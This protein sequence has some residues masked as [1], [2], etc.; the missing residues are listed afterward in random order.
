MRADHIAVAA[1]GDEPFRRGLLET[2]RVMVFWSKNWESFQT[3][4][5][6]FQ[7]LRDRMAASQAEADAL[8]RE[9]QG[10]EEDVFDSHPPL[11]T[12]L[13][14]LERVDTAAGDDPP[15]ERIRTELAVLLADLSSRHI[16]LYEKQPADEGST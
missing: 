4:G 9:E 7:Y 2:V 1:F 10:K 16:K 11:G 8:L 15:M 12:R 5:D 13:N 3:E 6:F 14:S